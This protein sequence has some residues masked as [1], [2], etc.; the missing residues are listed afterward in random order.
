MPIILAF[1]RG[2][3]AERRIVGNRLQSRASRPMRGDAQVRAAP[4]RLEPRREVFPGK[5]ASGAVPRAVPGD[6]LARRQD[7]R[8]VHGVS[9]VVSGVTVIAVLYIGLPELSFIGFGLW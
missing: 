6:D 5:A 2:E 4:D 1:D 8:V 7:Y 3:A 9:A